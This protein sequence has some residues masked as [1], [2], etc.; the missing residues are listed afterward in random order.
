[1]SAWYFWHQ[2]RTCS[3]DITNLI[4][5]GVMYG[6]YLYLFTAFA[7]KRYSRKPK[8]AAGEAEQGSSQDPTLAKKNQ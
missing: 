2:G 5:G 4:C 6:S 1:M 7:F 8:V 3:N